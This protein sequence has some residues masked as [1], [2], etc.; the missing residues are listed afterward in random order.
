MENKTNPSPAAPGALTG[1]PVPVMHQ[2][3][4]PVMMDT[5]E[6][7]LQ[8]F[9][10]HLITLEDLAHAFVL[11][12][13]RTMQIESL[14]QYCRK[15]SVMEV[16]TRIM[17]FMESR[18]G[19]EFR[20]YLGK[21]F[22]VGDPQAVVRDRQGNAL[23]YRAG[24]PLPPGKKVGG[25]K[26]IPKGTAVFI[27][28]ITDDLQ[29]VFCEDW[30]WTSTNNIRGGLYNETVGIDR[31][32]YESKEP[33]HKTV[34]TPDALIRTQATTF[35]IA[36]PARSIPK[37]TPVRVLRTS[38]VEQGNSLVRLPDGREV[39]TRTTNLSAQANPDGT[40][41]VTDSR[42]LIRLV[43]ADYPAAVGEI[44]QGSRVIVLQ[45]SAE[46][47][48][49][50]K[51][52]QVARTKKNAAGAFVR[53]ESQPPVWTAASNLVDFWADY[54]SNNAAW[55]KSDSSRTEGQYLGQIDL[56][57]VIGNSAGKQTLKK[58][59]T[60]LLIQYNKVLQAAA[61]AGI[62]LRLNSGFRT[63]PKQQVLWDKNPNPGQVARPGRS[64]HQ[65]GIAIDI[66]TSGFR[67]A[68]YLWM[69]QHGPALGWIR[70]VSDE[71]WHW[72]F[73]PQDAARFGFKLPGV[74]P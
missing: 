46:T 74:R 61:A 71:H 29:M 47:E 73:R 14:I 30:G 50:G 54:K 32:D 70:T 58:I 45:V 68:T 35:P 26:T 72:E 36:E 44:P 57:S 34:A 49:E 66:N 19:E 5:D 28:E 24:E 37:G 69:K 51:Y 23:V 60:G 15:C 12:Q 56:V 65:N 31:A 22:A 11:Q 48:P 20:S 62:D 53:D 33:G 43:K 39:W 63:F 40:R 21:R 8:R 13:F 3:Q 41:T 59:S 1:D 7:L 10:S 18:G 52:V 2:F 27:T 9:G 6:A 4:V 38:P 16:R 67:T 42:A 17:V 55:R 25:V 64:P